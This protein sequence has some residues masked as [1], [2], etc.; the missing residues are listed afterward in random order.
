MIFDAEQTDSPPVRPVAPSTDATAV[1][2]SQLTAGVRALNKD[3]EQVMP[4]L[5]GA[6]KQNRYFDEMQRQV[7]AAE[8]LSQAWRDWPLVIGIHE[9]ILSIRTNE[10]P[11]RYLLEHLENLLFQSGVEEY[12]FQGE[13]VEVELVEIVSSSG[14][15]S[16]FT[17]TTCKRPGLR[18]G[19]VPLRK[20]IVE[21]I[22]SERND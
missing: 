15:G 18:Q 11:D 6:L 22:R 16:R 19:P 9:A 1:L 14:Q 21:V 3:F 12:G 17:V 10:S 13:D 8:K 2:L 4:L 5:V 7:R 20:A